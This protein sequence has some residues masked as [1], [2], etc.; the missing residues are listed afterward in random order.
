LCG[1]SVAASVAAGVRAGAPMGFLAGLVVTPTR[2]KRRH[3]NE[4]A[5]DPSKLHGSE[6]CYGRNPSSGS[7][8]SGQL[9]N[10]TLRKCLESLGKLR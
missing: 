8:R 2:R 9:P 10:F 7:A 6:R 1:G 3:C 4:S 5:S